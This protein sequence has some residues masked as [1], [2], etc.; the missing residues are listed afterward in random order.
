MNLLN[1]ALVI[2]LLL[3]TIVLTAVLMVLPAQALDLS[4]QA[5]QALSA[6]ITFNV[7]L[8]IVLLGVIV[9]ILCFL[10][11]WLE[12]RAPTK[13]TVRVV[14]VEG[15]EAEMTTEAI[16]QR[17]AY[18]IE[19]LPEVVRVMPRVYPRGRAVEILLEVETGPEVHVPQKTAEIIHVA[20]E[21]VEQR[22][23][24]ELARVRVNIRHGPYTGRE[25]PVMPAPPRPAEA[26]PVR[27]APLSPSEPSQPP[28]PVREREPEEH[29]AQ[30]PS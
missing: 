7:Q 15:G 3:S 12:L 22:M 16:S 14:R 21:V 25:R 20:R 18:N 8:G 9:L 1:R 27:R 17:L 13:R 11:L 26:E 2:F 24:L 23:G 4:A 28:E 10:L 6:M 5:L 19:R 29:E 30:K